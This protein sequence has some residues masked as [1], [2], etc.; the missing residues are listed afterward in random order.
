MKLKY[1][2]AWLEVPL[3]LPPADERL[4]MCAM[5]WVV[6]RGAGRSPSPW[7]IAEIRRRS[8]QPGVAAVL[9]SRRLRMSG[10]PLALPPAD[11]RLLMCAMS[12]VV[13]KAG[14]RSPSPW[15]IGE[16]RRRSLQPGVAAVLFP[17]LCLR[18]TTVAAADQIQLWAGDANATATGGY[19]GYWLSQPAGQ[20]TPTW[21]STTGST[22]AYQ[23]NTP[24]LS[25]GRGFFL[26]TRPVANRAVW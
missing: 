12:W 4:L 11:E 14:G 20:P 5:S 19:T 26:K 16:I 7:V 24:I 21:L 13:A 15:V 25:A 18:G 6:A 1:E 3:A 9:P 23:N 10:V 17:S 22:N 8:L 2:V